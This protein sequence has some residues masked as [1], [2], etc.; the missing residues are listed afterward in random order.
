MMRDPLDARQMVADDYL[1]GDAYERVTYTSTR[2]TGSQVASL[3]YVRRRSLS[4]KELAASRGAYVG[5]DRKFIV[6]SAILP[7][8]FVPKPADQIED[9]DGN[10][11]TVL[12]AD[13]TVLGSKWY[14]VCRNPIIAF[15]LKD[16]IDI[17]APAISYDAQR[18]KLKAWP[19]DATPGGSVLYAS[20]A[21]RVQPLESAVVDELDVRGF[22]GTH[23]IYLSKQLTVDTA[24]NENRVK[25][26]V[27]ALTFYLDVLDYKQADQIDQLPILDTR[28][29]P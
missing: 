29:Q 7:K 11:W 22:K 14:L 17:Q 27:G 26:T 13:N 1:Y 6:P 9:A 2:R 8:G 16:V 28:L 12:E 18:T 23:A 21:C 4:A 24:W 3:D 25:W 20:L 19:D 10:P 15:D 5:N